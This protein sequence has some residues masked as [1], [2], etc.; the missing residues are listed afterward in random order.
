MAL[1]ARSTL[2]QRTTV[3]APLARSISLG[4]DSSSK[5]FDGEADDGAA[6]VD[7]C[8]TDGRFLA[9]DG[10]GDGAQDLEIRF[11]AQPLLF[12]EDRVPLD[13]AEPQV[14]GHDEPIHSGV[15]VR[16]EGGRLD[17]LT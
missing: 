3:V 5:A 1:V 4:L 7:R 11:L 2:S 6:D 12:E 15:R 14:Q 17:R 13:V 9:R 16:C 8:G 10:L